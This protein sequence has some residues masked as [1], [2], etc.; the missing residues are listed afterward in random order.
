[1]QAK[2][3]ETRIFCLAL[4]IIVYRLFFLANEAVFQTEGFASAFCKQAFSLKKADN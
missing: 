1:M 4:E 2:E 3:A